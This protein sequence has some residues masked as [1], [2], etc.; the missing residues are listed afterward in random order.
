VKQDIAKA[1][2][3]YRLANDQGNTEGSN[4]LRDV[5]ADLELNDDDLCESSDTVNDPAIET[6]QR[7]ARIQDLRAQITG[8]ETDAV[9]D[10]ISNNDLSHMGEHGKHKND[11]AITKGITKTMD[12][13]GTAVGAPTRVQAATLREKAAQL[14]EELAQLQS[15]DQASANGPI[16]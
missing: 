5:C 1:V 10:D 12:A 9:Q 2:A 13:I 14:R 4:N 7:R 3:W 15:L 16:P 8:L 11:N 6:V